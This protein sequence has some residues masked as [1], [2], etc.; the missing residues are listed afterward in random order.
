MY[1]EIKTVLFGHDGKKQQQMEA[2]T[3][4]FC[5]QNSLCIKITLNK[6]KPK[7]EAFINDLKHTY[8][9]D[10]HVQLMEMTYEKLIKK[11]TP[12]S[13]FVT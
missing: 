10:K 3:L 13:H 8:E 5:M 12:N 9:V 6:F 11:W 1:P 2:L 4:F 7:I